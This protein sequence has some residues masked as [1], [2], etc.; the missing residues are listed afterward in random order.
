[1]KRALLLFLLASLACAPAAA[2]KGPHAILTTPRETVEPGKPWQFTVE[3]Y[4]FAKSR[5]PAIIGRRGAHTVGAEVEKIRSAFPEAEAFRFTMVF[6]SRGS[7]KPL[8]FAGGRRFTF[9]AL[10]VGGGRMPR[11]HMTAFPIARGQTPRE[12]SDPSRDEAGIGG[13]LLP[14]LGVALAA[15]GV[16]AVTRRGSR[17]ARRP[18]SG[19]PLPPSRG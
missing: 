12:G 16:A 8:L 4:E 9:A 19:E 5:Q 3:L 7:W 6:P 1:M 10:R 15:A 13:W 14:L 17:R 18:P 11:E 2:A